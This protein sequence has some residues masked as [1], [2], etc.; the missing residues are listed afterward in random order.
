[1]VTVTDK[2]ERFKATAE[3]F[4]EKDI[5]IF[6]KDIDDNIYFARVLLVGEDT[7][8]IECFGPPKKNGLKYHL[9]WPLI[10]ELNEYKEGK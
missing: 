8:T 1:M 2:V 3:L 7:I 9:Y 5:D 6:I 10:V 4:L